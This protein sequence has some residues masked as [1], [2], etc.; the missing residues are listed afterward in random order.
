MK[1]LKTRDSISGAAR[2]FKALDRAAVLAEHTK[3]IAIRTKESV[4]AQRR[5]QAG[6]AGEPENYAGEKVEHGANQAVR[7]VQQLVPQPR[8]RH[9]K[10]QKQPRQQQFSKPPGQTAANLAPGQQP[11]GPPPQVNP[12]Q[13]ARPSYMTRPPWAGGSQAGSKNMP[14]LAGDKTGGVKAASK[15]L[16][17]TGNGLKTAQA[18]GQVSI[19][20]AGAAASAENTRRTA[21]VAAKAQQMAQAAAKTAVKAVKETAKAAVEIT[22]AA[23]ES[24]KALGVLIAEGGWVVILAVIAVALV[25]VLC[26]SAY[27][28]FFAAS[29]NP[30]DTDAMTLKLAQVEISAELAE[31]VSSIAATVPHNKLEIHGV[32]AGW[33]DTL[34]VYAIVVSYDPD[35]TAGP[36]VMD[37]AQKERLREIYWDMNTITWDTQRVPAAPEA[38]EDA[39]E[40]ILLTITILP[41][42]AAQAAAL[43]GFDA[44]QLEILTDMFLP[45]YDA[46]WAEILSGY[47]PGGG[48]V[49]QTAS[50]RVP[51]GPFTWPLVADHRLTSA[52][53]S[54]DDPFNPG[55]ADFHSGI[56]VAA[57]GGTPI[58]AAAD[59]VVVSANG[60]DLLGGG[61][62]YYVKLSHADGYE[63]LYAHCSQ[64][65]VVLGQEVVRGQVI[66]Y[67]G[68]TGRSTGNHLHWEVYRSGGR[69]DPLGF[70]G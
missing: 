69:V 2:T 50:S 42:S 70:F 5:E 47:V 46:V 22:K 52:F 49:M 18:A 8:R 39:P 35:S 68:T 40:E 37:R 26:C 6:E 30:I 55:A 62:G 31:H 17:T 19:K 59:G 25:V 38:G 3:N 24:I 1:D 51:T 21:Q 61:W 66:A 63:T 34:A 23:L 4:D 64:I 11:A 28:L 43:Y 53:G 20:T 9:K 27:S 7:R 14:A 45:G 16:K 57:P 48:A 44:G 60:T 65:A 15:G 32:A 33:Q 58:L 54:R 29:V 13:T 36:M 10:I 56:D 12:P 67:V 41:L